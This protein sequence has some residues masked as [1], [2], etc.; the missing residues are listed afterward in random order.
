MSKYLSS[1]NIFSTLILWGVVLFMCTMLFLGI[2]KEQ[3]PLAPILI[4]S[5]VIALLLWTL[6]DT[7]YVVNEAFLLYRSGPFRGKIAIQNIKKITYFSGF[8]I[9]VTM[10][11]ALDYKGFIVQYNSFDD[12]FISPKNADLFIAEILKINPEIEVLPKK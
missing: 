4:L 11:P 3:L 2:L 6:L 8:N 5:L 7:R 9:P 1:K 10:K 12:V